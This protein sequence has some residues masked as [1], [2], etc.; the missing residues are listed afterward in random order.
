MSPQ[1]FLLVNLALSFYLTGTIWA[2]EVDIFRSWRLVDAKDFHQIQSAHWKKLPYWVFAPL[3]LALAG[4]VALIFYHPDGS[5]AWVI[6]SNLAAQLMS[7]LL[8]A[9]FWGRLQGK[10]SRDERGPDSPYLAKFLATH[11]IRTLLI[12]TYSAILLVWAIQVLT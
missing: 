5:Q 3:G 11:W 2:L 12:N 8:T 9:I 1:T 4:S 10:L 7:H 6:W